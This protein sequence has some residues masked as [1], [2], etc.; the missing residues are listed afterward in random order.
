MMAVSVAIQ[1][2][3]GGWK[4]VITFDTGGYIGI[5][6]FPA[7]FDQER[8]PYYGWLAYVVSLGSGNYAA[9]PA[10]HLAVYLAATWLFV[11]ELRRFGLSALAGL[12]AGATLLFANSLLIVTRDVHPESLAISAA[13]F[14]FAGT[15][16][17]ATG[18]RGR[19]AW[20]A[21]LAGSGLSYAL[22]PSFLPL[23]VALPALFLCLRAVA[24]RPF[25]IGRA[26]TILVLSALPF[27]GIGS[28]RYSLVGDF[29]IVSFGGYVMSGTAA[30][31][32]S[33]DIVA[34]LPDDVKPLAAEI[35]KERRA[36]EDSGAFIGIPRNAS[37]VRSYHSVTL[38]YFDVLARTHDDM[39]RITGAKRR[40]GESLV[41][42]NRRM[43]R[44][45][46]AVFRA[47]PDRYAAW[48]VGASSRLFG[49]SFVTNLP[50]ALA[51]VVIVLAWPWR[52]LFR[53]ETIVHPDSRA[54]FPVLGIC[55]ILWLA[56]SAPLTVL[57]HAPAN[58]FIETSSLLVAA[59]LVYWASLLVRRKTLP[60]GARA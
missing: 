43:I 4:P 47:A 50:A 29:N 30:L 22:R 13:L 32:L 6:G 19:W 17:L 58:R 18:E 37:D 57:I 36:G 46:L 38:A 1:F 51:L 3:A 52:L 10:I 55:A 24:R 16:H 48:L 23:I 45:S 15:V 20:I 44:F 54:D 41:D 31:M 14:A 26:A 34:R 33:D 49:R 21:V 9:V 27:L 40:A 60:G 11:I 59:P 56:A 39:L 7:M 35:L 8:A 5:H 53:G 28:L 25:A 2:A 42:Y 12:A